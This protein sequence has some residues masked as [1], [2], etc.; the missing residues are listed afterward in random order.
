[1]IKNLLQVTVW[2]LNRYGPN[3]FLGEV[4]LDLDNVMN[5][6]PT[7]HILRPHEEMPGYSV[8]DAIGKQK[9]SQI[10]YIYILYNYCNNS[11]K[12]YLLL[13]RTC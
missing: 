2:D 7:W 3:D 6:E 13:E 12:K 8:S 5:H 9:N 4:L 11:Q 10:Y 1:M